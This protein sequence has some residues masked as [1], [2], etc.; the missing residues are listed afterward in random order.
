M[1]KSITYTENVTLFYKIA[2]TAHVVKRSPVKNNGQLKEIAVLVHFKRMVVM[3]VLD[4]N[5]NSLLPVK[6]SR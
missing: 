3:P 5:G 4:K 1:V 6:F 2:F